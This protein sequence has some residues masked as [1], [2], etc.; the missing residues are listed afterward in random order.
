[1]F[2]LL[3][4][5]YRFVPEVPKCNTVKILEYLNLANEKKY[6]KNSQKTANILELGLK[7]SLDGILN[8]FF[9]IF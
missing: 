6:S 4:K 3:Y 9:G 2:V 8:T 7:N 5:K 1:M